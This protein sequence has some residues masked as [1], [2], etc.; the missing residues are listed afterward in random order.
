MVEHVIGQNDIHAVISH[1]QLL[2]IE[3]E[4]GGGRV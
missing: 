3:I 4:A 2:G 1:G